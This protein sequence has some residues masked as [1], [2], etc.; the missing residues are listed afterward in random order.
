MVKKYLMKNI[1]KIHPLTYITILIALITGNFKNIFIFMTIILIHEMGHFLTALILKWKVMKVVIL[2]FGVITIFN[3]SLNKPLKEEF[4][5]AIMGPVVQILFTIFMNILNL[6]IFN[7]FSFIILFLNLI[8]IYPMDGSKI[9]NIF[10]NKFFPFKLSHS[11]TN[12]LSLFL[13]LFLLFLSIFKHELLYI[14]FSILIIIKLKDEFINHELM[15]QKFLY[16]RYLYNFKFKKFKIIQDINKFY[17]DNYHYFKTKKGIID[18][19]QL[20]YIKYNP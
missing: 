1:F 11:I 8:P 6:K 20:L 2:P 14:I 5:I 4:L 17:K 12:Y 16:E 10:L 19:K 9:L 3:E 15:Y 7:Y 18:E 13:I